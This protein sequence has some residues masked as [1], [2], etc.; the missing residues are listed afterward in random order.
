MGAEIFHAPEWELAEAEAKYYAE[1]L[2]KLQNEYGI[3]IT[4][5]AMVW[6]NLV[7]VMAAIHV[8]R[9]IVT[10]QRLMGETVR[11]PASPPDQPTTIN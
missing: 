10:R 3:A 5:Q 9:A 1:A 2:V 4:G 6:S 8:P 11:R 7:A